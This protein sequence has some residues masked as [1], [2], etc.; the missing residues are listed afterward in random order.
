MFISQQQAIWPSNLKHS[1]LNNNLSFLD[2][3]L[4]HMICKTE[5]V[6][7]RQDFLKLFSEIFAWFIV[8]LTFPIFI[9]E[10]LKVTVFLVTCFW[11]P[12]TILH[13]SLINYRDDDEPK[14][15]NPVKHGG[16]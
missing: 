14:F 10:Y 13:N 1:M 15:T 2:Y 6:W 8:T 12:D 11:I 5:N 3:N 9:Q 7:N 16:H 4:N